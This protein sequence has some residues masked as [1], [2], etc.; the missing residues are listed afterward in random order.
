[1][2]AQ[3]APLALELNMRNFIRSYTHLRN[4]P[5]SRVRDL[6]AIS[7]DSKLDRAMQVVLRETEATQPSTSPKITFQQLDLGTEGIGKTTIAVYAFNTRNAAKTFRATCDAILN[8]D[9][10]WPDYSLVK[11]S[12]KV[13]PVPPTNHHVRYGISEH[14]YRQDATGEQIF[15]EGRDLSYWRMTDS[16]GVFVWDYVDVDDLHPLRK[17]T[18]VKRNTVGAYVWVIC[19]RSVLVDVMADVL[20]VDGVERIVCRNICSDMQ[21]LVNLPELAL[22]VARFA[23]LGDMLLF[24]TIKEDVTDWHDAVV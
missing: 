20:W 1:M 14:L 5:H 21:V 2:F 15:S 9:A 11:S 24:E 18:A 16:C 8:C 7:T 6:E 3:S 23:L 10:V 12:L 22:D 17:S 19:D 4:D 13:I